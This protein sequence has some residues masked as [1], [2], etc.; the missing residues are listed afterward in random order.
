MKYLCEK[1]D[2]LNVFL[3]DTPMPDKDKELIR[4]QLIAMD[5]CIMIMSKRLD[6]LEGNA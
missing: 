6:R 2:K 5:R 3:V 1:A 4:K